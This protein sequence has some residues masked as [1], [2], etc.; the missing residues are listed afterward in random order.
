MGGKGSGTPKAALLKLDGTQ[1]DKYGQVSQSTFFE[2]LDTPVE[3]M[4]NLEKT[5]TPEQALKFRNHINRMGVGTSAIMPMLCGGKKCPMKLCPFHEGS[6]GYPIGDPCPLEANLIANWTKSYIED[7]S[8]DI[9]SRSEM[10]LVNKLVEC[11]IIDMRANIG[12][13]ADE[14]GWTLLK[15]DITVSDKGT[16]E[17][18][19]AHP[20]LE[21]KDRVQRSR[22]R[23]LESLAATRKE[24]YKRAAA[25]KKRE[26]EDIGTHFDN[27]KKALGVASSRAKGASIE[28]LKADA[29]K[30]TKEDKEKNIEDA[31]WTTEEEL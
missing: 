17:M 4:R 21:V 9:E 18:T 1:I 7:L 22:E 2:F 29:D 3:Q 27:L 23:V 31:D 20:L 14:E 8:V 11:D 12:L 13:G 30:M 19:N 28:Q 16:A 25:L 6:G 5:M 24:K 15:V 26:D 10:I